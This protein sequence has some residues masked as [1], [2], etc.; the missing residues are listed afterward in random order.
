MKPTAGYTEYNWNTFAFRCID[1]SC[2]IMR[3]N[4]PNTGI[5]AQAS[6]FSTGPVSHQLDH[7]PDHCVNKGDYEEERDHNNGNGEKHRF[8]VS[9]TAE[10]LKE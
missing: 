1:L 7:L 5:A 2:T 3:L 8:I 4:C 6:L 9:P 10:T